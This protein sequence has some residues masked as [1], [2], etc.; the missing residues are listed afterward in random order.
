MI[1]QF[2]R[3][4]KTY[5]MNSSVARAGDMDY[6]LY[7]VGTV[8]FGLSPSHQLTQRGPFQQGDSYI[9][10]RLDPRIITLPLVV[11]ATS[12]EDS[13][14]KRAKLA[15]LFRISD[16]VVTIRLSWTDS[17]GSYDRSIQGRVLG[18]LSFD[19]DAQ[20]DTIRTT[21]Q[22]RC[23]DPTWYDST[24]TPAILTSTLFGTPTLY[25]KTYPVLYG[26][27]VV[28]KITTINYTGTW[29]SYPIIQVT[30]PATNLAITDTLNHTISFANPI[31]TGAF[32]TINL[33]YGIYTVFDQF[34]NNKFS[35]LTAISNLVD[36][37]VYAESDQVPNGTNTISVSA[38]GTNAD[39]NVTMYYTQRYI[40]V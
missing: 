23:N 20:Y 36:W 39:T 29:D 27:A 14:S 13:F 5:E 8:G 28:D 15:S 21:V 33:N 26:S 37:R 30:G 7:L 32:W 31:P 35:E 34:G 4:N 38:T 6:P 10:V 25:P 17:T 22:I 19:T 1:L 2:I 11:A 12:P 16:D 3:N 18:Q 9:G 40:G 24:Q